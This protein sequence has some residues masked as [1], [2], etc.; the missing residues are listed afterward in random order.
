MEEPDPRTCV[1][2][3]HKKGDEIQTPQNPSFSV[4]K[5]RACGFPDNT[6]ICKMVTCKEK[7]NHCFCYHCWEDI[8]TGQ[9]C[10]DQNPKKGSCLAC[11]PS[12]PL[13]SPVFS[14]PG[15]V[16]AMTPDRLVDN[17]WKPVVDVE[18]GGREGKVIAV[19]TDSNGTKTEYTE[20]SDNMGD[21]IRYQVANNTL[22][23]GPSAN[24]AS[25]PSSA[26][27]ASYASVASAIEEASLGSGTAVAAAAPAPAPAPSPAPAPA[28]VP[29]PEYQGA[30]LMDADPGASDTALM[31]CIFQ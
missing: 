30:A 7:P 12:E 27:V 21:T 10:V 5:T 6:N 2:F 8:V 17:R 11:S 23:K 13:S 26:S 3:Y 24:S 19:F 22:N 18:K 31:S 29:V 28:P 9:W 4:T 25:V 20:V 16:M 15:S 14:S 1:F